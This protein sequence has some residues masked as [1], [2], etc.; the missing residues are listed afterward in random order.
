MTTTLEQLIG[1][2]AMPAILTMEVQRGVVGDL[3]AIRPL[4]LEQKRRTHMGLAKL[5]TRT[6]LPFAGERDCRLCFDECEA[7]GYHAIEMREIKLEIDL[8]DIP[9]GAVSDDE[10]EEMSRIQAPFIDAAKC[11]GCGLCEYRCHAAN[12]KQQK[13]LAAS[14]IVTL[15]E[16]EDRHF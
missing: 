7:A 5:N 8:S 12:V 1:R 14:A 11:V 4:A 9:P 3:A 13:L 6:C 16:N 15:A 10:L 2:S